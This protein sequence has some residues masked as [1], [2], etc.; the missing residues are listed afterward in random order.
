V[1]KQPSPSSKSPEQCNGFFLLP[2]TYKYSCSI[3]SSLTPK[4]TPTLPYRTQAD[5][6][7]T[8]PQARARSPTLVSP[9]A[10]SARH[11]P[12][13][14]SLLAFTLIGSR[15][16]LPPPANHDLHAS[17][18]SSRQSQVFTPSATSMPCQLSRSTRPLHNILQPASPPAPKHTPTHLYRTQVDHDSTPQARARSPTHVSPPA[19]SARHAPA[20]L[21]L[22]AFVPIGSHNELPPPANHD[23]HASRQS[24][25]HL[26]PSCHVSRRVPLA[27]STTTPARFSTR[28]KEGA[29]L[30]KVA[31]AS[32]VAA[33]SE[34]RLV[35]II[36]GSFPH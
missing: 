21:P 32:P 16:E 29:R 5:H 11:A 30:D 20:S 17:H 35:P 33:I 25:R 22:L 14:L 3:C 1:Q 24:S 36:G 13:S 4:R 6:D 9:P 31:S 28:K 7:S 26:Q 19:P 23:L 27:H 15:N 8:L 12:A 18:K 10:P 2:L 34:W